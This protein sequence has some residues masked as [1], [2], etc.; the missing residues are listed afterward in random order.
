MCLQII[1]RAIDERFVLANTF[2]IQEKSFVEKRR[3]IDNNIST[4][5]ELCGVR[6]AD[7]GIDYIDLDAWVK[8]QQS[9]PRGFYPRFAKPIVRHQQLAVEIAWLDVSTVCQNQF[10]DTC[11]RQFIR[12]DASQ[13]AAS[14]H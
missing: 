14:R 1:H 13:S 3:A 4:R 6:F 9:S 2:S 5:D 7:V 8:F 12:D 10:A 11:R